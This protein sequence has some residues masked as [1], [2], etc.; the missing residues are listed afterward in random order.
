MFWASVLN[1]FAVWDLVSPGHHIISAPWG[2]FLSFSLFKAYF[3]HEK[4]RHPNRVIPPWFTSASAS[5]YDRHTGPP[6]V[7]REA[8]GRKPGTFPCGFGLW[9]IMLLLGWM[10]GFLISRRYGSLWHRRALC[11]GASCLAPRHGASSGSDLLF[12]SS[13]EQSLHTNVYQCALWTSALHILKH[14]SSSSQKP[15][16]EGTVAF[17]IDKEPKTLTRIL[18]NAANDG[19]EGGLRQA[20]A[21]FVLAILSTGTKSA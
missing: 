19:A 2:W 8:S 15:S 4:E 16:E 3:F 5:Q 9:S 18:P 21:P 7:Y 1:W 6:A 14:L 13:S 11:H 10:A 12:F 17:F 20:G